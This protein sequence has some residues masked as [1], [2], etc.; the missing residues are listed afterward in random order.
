MV[1]RDLM[2]LMRPHSEYTATALFFESRPLNGNAG[3]IPFV[4]SYV[5]PKSRAYTRL[6]GNV[7]GEDANI[8]IQ[9]DERLDFQPG[10]TRIRLPDGQLYIVNQVLYDY[11]KAPKQALRMFPMPVGVTRLIRMIP[12]KDPWSN[13]E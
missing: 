9:T 10:K 3:G 8:A 12:V 7:T 13:T 5:E 4:F 11:D 2:D 6:I 1:I